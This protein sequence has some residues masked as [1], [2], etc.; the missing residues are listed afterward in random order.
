MLR[1]WSAFYP[2]G[3]SL[4]QPRSAACPTPTCPSSCI[5]DNLLKIQWYSHF[6]VTQPLEES[7]GLGSMVYTPP[8]LYVLTSAG[9]SASPSP[10]SCWPHALASLG[11]FISWDVPWSV[12]ASK[13][14]C[15]FLWG[16]L[17][18]AHGHHLAW[19]SLPPGAGLGSL[20]SLLECTVHPL[21]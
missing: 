3:H 8:D 9:S 20:V 12:L 14:T 15:C 4:T 2:Q 13:H 17:L 5:S 6:L 18:S 1:D 7:G 16:W 19:L 10:D 11:P 21:W